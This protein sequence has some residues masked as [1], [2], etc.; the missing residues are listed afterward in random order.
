MRAPGASVSAIGKQ[1]PNNRP[2]VHSRGVMTAWQTTFLH[3]S[4]VT[5]E[6]VSGHPDATQ[7]IDDGDTTGSAALCGMVTPG[8][9]TLT[10]ALPR[11]VLIPVLYL[12]SSQHPR[13]QRMT[14]QNY[15]LSTHGTCSPGD[16]WEAAPS[17]PLL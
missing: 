17:P 1:T 9:V 14:G 11:R 15:L 3:P 13:F 8:A 2:E 5:D 12:L 10:L 16:S 6:C 4:R 7:G